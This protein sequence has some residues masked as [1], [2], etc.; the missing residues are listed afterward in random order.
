MLGSYFL[1]IFAVACGLALVKVLTS[2]TFDAK[3]E[4]TSE[5]SEIPME[6]I[7]VIDMPLSSPNKDPSFNSTDSEEE[8]SQEKLEVEK[9][10]VLP[11]IINMPSPTPTML[12]T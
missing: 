12:R 6:K 1:F 9:E 8:T 10:K 4:V 5:I 3:M 2:K 11:V 7:F